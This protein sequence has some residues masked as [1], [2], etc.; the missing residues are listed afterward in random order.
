MSRQSIGP[1]PGPNHHIEAVLHQGPNHHIEAVLHQGPN[2]HIEAVLHQGPNHHIKAVLHQGPNHHIK[3]VL[4]QK[5][6][7]NRATP[8]SV[9]LQ[10]LNRAT[11][12]SVWPSDLITILQRIAAS[13]IEAMLCL[14]ILFGS[15]KQELHPPQVQVWRRPLKSPTSPKQLAFR[16]RIRI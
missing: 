12:S 16:L 10:G 9:P 11:P 6:N 7:H 8:S 13:T 14:Q 4:H 5:P 1:T 2:H 15:S 3:A